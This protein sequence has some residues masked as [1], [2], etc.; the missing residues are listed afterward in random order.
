[1]IGEHLGRSRF[2]FAINE[3][4][5][6]VAEANKYFSEQAPW[7]LLESD[8]N[9]M[10][11]V[12]HVALQL[13]DDAKT[14]LT[15]FLPRSSQQVYGMLGGTGT[16]SDMPRVDEVDEDGGPAYPVITG[17]YDGA[18]RWG[19]QPVRPGTPLSPPTPLF[20]KLDKS[21]VAEE[22]ARLGD[23]WPGFAARTPRGD[24][25][26]GDSSVVTARHPPRRCPGRPSHPPTWT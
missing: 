5:R 3:A 17:Q 14:L 4:M 23:V 7:K 20:T 15:P 16:W 6:T 11:T 8:P 18:A 26:R 21:V 22:L 19:S 10:R 1:M 12:L 25:S 13:I 24:S 2:K 9:R